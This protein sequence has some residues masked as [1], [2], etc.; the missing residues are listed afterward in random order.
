[1]AL[2]G[3]DESLA[4]AFCGKLDGIMHTAAPCPA[5]VKREWIARLGAERVFEMYGSTQMVGAAICNG[6]EWLERPGTVG[7]PFMTQVRIFSEEGRRLGPGRVGEVTM[8]SM[9]TRRITPT[10]AAHVR[11]HPGGF[12]GV[13]DLGYLDTEG[14]LFLTDRLD[15]VIIVGGANVS[16]REVEN[17]LTSHPAVREAIVSGRSHDLLGQTVHAA[18]VRTS[19]SDITAAELRAYCTGLL[20]AHKVPSVEIVEELA[21][22]RAGKVQ[23]FRYS[24]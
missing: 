24:D 4:G 11:A 3:G 7:R 23:R 18:V 2:I 17:A 15:D 9:G 8:R 22:S 16:A 14:Y 19:N 13:G 1:M 5:D 6:A 10:S 20:A 12:Y 21:R